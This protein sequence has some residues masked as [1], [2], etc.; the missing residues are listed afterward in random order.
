MPVPVRSER[1]A[2]LISE[3]TASLAV[4]TVSLGCVR[5]TFGDGCPKSIFFASRDPSMNSIMRRV[6]V[7]SIQECSPRH[8]ERPL[9]QMKTAAW[10]SVNKTQQENMHGT[11]IRGC[12]SDHGF[13]PSST[14]DPQESSS[15]LVGLELSSTTTIIADSICFNAASFAGD[16][17]ISRWRACDYINTVA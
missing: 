4:R 13:R 8:P 16:A 9:S 17:S 6:G 2:W 5:L 10:T 7:P 1:A 14:Q 3:R 15:R 11:H 12:L